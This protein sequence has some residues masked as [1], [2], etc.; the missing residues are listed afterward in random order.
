MHSV[1]LIVLL[2]CDTSTFVHNYE[3]LVKQTMHGIDCRYTPHTQGSSDLTTKLTLALTP[4][5]DIER[6]AG[7]NFFPSLSVQDQN[8]LELRIVNSLWHDISI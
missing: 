8:M 4:L 6:I 7:V 3:V 5:R 1:I 2:H